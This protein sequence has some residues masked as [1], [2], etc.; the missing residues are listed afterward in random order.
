MQGK[1]QSS[2]SDSGHL[3]EFS[4]VY[5]GTSCLKHQ[6]KKC[7]D[8]QFD[9]DEGIDVQRS[10][11][12]QEFNNHDPPRR[13]SQWPKYPSAGNGSSGK[14]KLPQEGLNPLAKSVSHTNYTVK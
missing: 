13:C 11:N 2:S 1:T 4:P 8:N 7:N 6:L 5:S 14:N 3:L 12:L 10:Y 9:P